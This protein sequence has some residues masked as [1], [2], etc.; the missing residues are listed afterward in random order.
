MSAEL[1]DQS[2]T[3]DVV[4]GDFDMFKGLFKKAEMM[5][6]YLDVNGYQVSPVSLDAIREGVWNLKCTAEDSFMILRRNQDTEQEQYLQSA[7]PA[8]GYG[9]PDIFSVEAGYIQEGQWM[10]FAHKTVDR[11]EVL[12]RFE[13]YFK[14]GV[15]NHDGFEDYDVY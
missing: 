15:L 7:L 4:K 5:D 11:N 10:H 8:P 14:T 2:H 3:Y 6:W 1:L 13:E 12:H 9:S